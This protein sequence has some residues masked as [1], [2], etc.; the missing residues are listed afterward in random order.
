M[1]PA[2]VYDRKLGRSLMTCDYQDLHCAS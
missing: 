1:L 2:R